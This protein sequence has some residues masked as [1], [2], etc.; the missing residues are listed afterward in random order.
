MGQIYKDDELA[1][2]LQ[3]LPHKHGVITLRGVRGREVTTEEHLP[4]A[5]PNSHCLFRKG[6]MV[7]FLNDEVWNLSNVQ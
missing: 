5:P 7:A 6:A 2:K 3:L 1:V 4:L